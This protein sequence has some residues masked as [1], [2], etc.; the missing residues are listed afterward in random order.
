MDLDAGVAR[1]GKTKNGDAR[2]LVLLPQVV[3]ALRPFASSD[4]R[5]FVFGSPRMRYQT[6]ADIGSAWKAAIARSQVEN[7]RFHDLRHTSAS[8]LAQAGVGINTIREILGHRKIDMS[9][10]YAHLDT[11][12]RAAAMQAALGKIG[13]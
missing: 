8:Y 4:A 2:T 10:R 9:L 11:G 5:R 1:L 6:P 7:F 12:T 13:V 3:E